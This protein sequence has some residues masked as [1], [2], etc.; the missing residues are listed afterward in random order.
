[1]HMPFAALLLFAGG[2][3]S[4]SDYYPLQVGNTWAYVV[5]DST[6]MRT[7]V[8]T[9]EFRERN[10]QGIPTVVK[11][12]INRVD[13]GGSGWGEILLRDSGNVVYASTGQWNFNSPYP[14]A[15][16]SYQGI[17]GFEGKPKVNWTVKFVGTV[18]VPVGTFDSCYS[19]DNNNVNS[20]WEYVFAPGIGLIKSVG[21]GG[22]RVSVLVSSKVNGISAV[23]SRPGL[24]ITPLRRPDNLYH[25]P[26]KPAGYWANGR[27]A[28]MGRW[29]D[30]V[31]GPKI[32][33]DQ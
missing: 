14:H 24:R 18:K 20:R 32:P 1:M 11:Y 7:G 21:Y 12:S 27:L 2:A 10:V 3:I 25:L 22:D 4:A 28:P 13:G 30:A 29:P 15:L 31:K 23:R 33:L 17:T 9:T 19:I 26:G 5:Y 8:D 6:G 16:H